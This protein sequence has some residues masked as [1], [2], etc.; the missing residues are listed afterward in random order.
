MS[1]KENDFSPTQQVFMALAPAIT[2]FLSVVGSSLIMLS[3]LHPRKGLS[4]KDR[5]LFGLSLTDTI[6]SLIIIPWSLFIPEGMTW[7]A[8]GNDATCTAQ[9]F[10]IQLGH[11]PTFYQAGLAHY[12]YM[13]IRYGTSDQEFSKRYERWI[14]F[15]SVLWPLGTAV[16]GLYLDL[17][18]FSHVG[19]WIAPNPL[20][21]NIDDQV[22]CN[23]GANAPL[24]AYL[25]TGIPVAIFMFYIT[26]TM[27]QIYLKV[28][29]VSVRAA[30]RRFE[31]VQMVLT[32][33]N[34][35]YPSS[36]ASHISTDN[37]AES[38][39][40]PTAP[41]PVSTRD[42]DRTRSA[43]MQAF[44]YIAVYCSTHSFVF[45]SANMDL[46][47]GWSPFAIAFL[48][49]STFPL[50]GIFN[51]FIFLRPRIGSLKKRN[52]SLGY[53]KAWYM[54]IFSTGTEALNSRSNPTRPKSP[55][56]SSE[57]VSAATT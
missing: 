44:L 12:Y 47:A 14:H 54:A 50:Q 28:R 56:P 36:S 7:G 22:E 49:V 3:L 13:T 8:R 51:L 31:S 2:G 38:E 32:A 23:S 1:I 20:G 11:A 55:P 6:F 16:A 57:G 15:M 4:V 25:F 27:L 24:Y 29:E 46:F 43:A 21:C 53:W 18:N 17:F 10:L 45:V 33:T 19:C 42:A 41:R 52:S 26:Y 30:T 39:A 9:G 5:L 40:A 48:G 35:N 34:N 37:Q